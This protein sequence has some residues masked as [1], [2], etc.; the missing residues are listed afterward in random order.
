MV[1][2]CGKTFYAELTDYD[3]NQVDD[4]LRDNVLDKLYLPDLIHSVSANIDYSGFRKKRDCT[5]KGSSKYLAETIKQW[6][7][8][9]EKIEMWS[10][11]L[12]YD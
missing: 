3:Q 8:Q 7:S 11:C 9:F 12:S 2:E 6:L 4:W 10:D 1:S 5:Y